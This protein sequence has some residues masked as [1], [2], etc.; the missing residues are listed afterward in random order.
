MASMPHPQ[1]LV[2]SSCLPRFGTVALLLALALLTGCPA[3]DPRPFQQFSQSVQEIHTGT[4]QVLSADYELAR[5]RMLRRM[6]TDLRAA[7]KQ[8]TIEQVQDANGVIDVYRWKLSEEPLALAIRRY[9]HAVNEFNDVLVTYAAQLASL[10]GPGVLSEEDLADMASRLTANANEAAASLK[11]QVDQDKLAIFSTVAAGA[12]QQ[13]VTSKQRRHLGAALRENQA[14]VEEMSR[15]G[16]E[17]AKNLALLLW[18]E[19]LILQGE[20]KAEIAGAPDAAARQPL[21]QK[22]AALDEQFLDL[23]EALKTLDDAYATLPAAHAEL[24]KNLEIDYVSVETIRQL[25]HLGK[26]LDRIHKRLREERP[27]TA[28]SSP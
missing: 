14:W 15:L 20:M 4:D 27:G 12:F 19:F 26:R 10:A 22:K 16:R 17:A 13:Y 8:V 28:P 2:S 23:L 5:A 9:R 1:S 24:A 25:A 11:L 21:F 6:Q 18:Q 3:I 7:L